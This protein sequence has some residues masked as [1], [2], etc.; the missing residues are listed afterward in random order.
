MALR[1]S[2]LLIQYPKLEP[3]GLFC[4]KHTG[5]TSIP[6]YPFYTFIPLPPTPDNSEK[7]QKDPHFNAY[8]LFIEYFRGGCGACHPAGQDV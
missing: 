2:S 8:I 5:Y 1:F 6:L 7:L 3:R 4:F